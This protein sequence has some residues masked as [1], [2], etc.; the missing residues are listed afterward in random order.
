MSVLT[1]PIY[2]LLF[3]GPRGNGKTDVMLMDFA[4]DCQKGY[5]SDWRGILFRRTYPELVD[6]IEKTK[7][8]YPQIF[9]NS[10]KYNETKSMWVWSTGEK[11]LLRP[12][13]QDSNYWAYHGH[14]Y[15]WQCWEELCT[16]YSLSGYLKMMSCC[17]SSNPQVA[18]IARIR[19]TA[20]PGGVGHN[21][22]RQR[23]KLPEMG[24]RIIR[25]GIDASGNPEPHRIAIL[26]HTAENRAL[27]DA[28]P[29]YIARL[30]AS[31]STEAERRAWVY[32]DWLIV[33][34][35][36]FDDVWSQDVNCLVPFKIPSDWSIYRSY[37]WGGSKPWAC[38][39]FAKSNGEDV[40]MADGKW[41][42]TVRGDTYMI[43]EEYGWSGKIDEGNKMDDL[44]IAARI[45]ERELELGIYG[46]V[47]PG[48]SEAAIFNHDTYGISVADTMS[49]TVRLYDGRE[50]NG[51]T[52]LP[53]DKGQYSRTQGW[54]VMRR[55][56]NDAKPSK[57]GP[58][59]RPGL[60]VF[61]TCEHTLRTIPVLPRDKNKADDV[62]TKSEDH[63]ADLIR[64][65]CRGIGSS[66]S[67]GL[68]QG[69]S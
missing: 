60:F 63:L 7:K 26:G 23:F 19:S 6:V 50:Y 33:S 18:K 59:E 55:M 38:G 27:M 5:G 9:G 51:P 34:G 47:L 46:R 53:A 64:Y 36:M 10:V 67:Y 42:S 30:E 14:S 25:G 12:F 16:H 29:G 17:R 54:S 41:R 39:W 37:D 13:E 20:N 52:F 40:Q 61:N 43:G 44:K 58:R 69:M 11:L 4:K 2:E 31:A 45:I 21:A 35:G 3:G 48:L 1:C 24:N 57:T 66:L 68:T 32:G 8:W 56:I 15:P 28:D 65:F 62:D 22:V 49:K